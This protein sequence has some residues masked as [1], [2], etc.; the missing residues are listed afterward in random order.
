MA[1]PQAQS[2]RRQLLTQTYGRSPA[3]EAG[4]ERLIAGN[5]LQPINYLAHGVAAARPVCRLTLNDPAGRLCGY[6]T[7]FLIA[8]TVLLTNNHVFPSAD[9]LADTHIRRTALSR[10]GVATTEATSAGW[11]LT[12]ISR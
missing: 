1:S 6:A 5:E 3:T 10:A 9:P 7:G 2:E 8:P 4:F 12:A 11:C